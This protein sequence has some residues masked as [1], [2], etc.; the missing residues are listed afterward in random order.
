MDQIV[1]DVTDLGEVTAGD[2]A[3]IVGRQGETMIGAGELAGWVDTISYELVTGLA[4]RL[5]RAYVRHGRLVGVADLL[6]ERDIAAEPCDLAFRWPA[7]IETRALSG[8]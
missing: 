5:P 6:G 4:P 2:L 3:T 7:S 8:S 1:I